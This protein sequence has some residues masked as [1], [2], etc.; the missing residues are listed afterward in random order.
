MSTERVKCLI[1]G[2]GPAGYTAAIYTGRANINP[3]LYEG[4]QPGGQ[5]TITTEV[6]KMID[7]KNLK[8][9]YLFFEC[10]NC[11]NF[12]IQGLSCHSRFCP[13]CGK[14]Y[15]DARAI[16]VS[17]KCLKVPHRHITWTISDK[18]RPYFRKYHELYD[19]L[20]GAVNDALTY[21]IQGKSKAAKERG[22]C[23]GFIS[24]IHTFG[25][26]M[27]FNPHIHTLVAECT[28]DKNGNQKPYS[29]FNYESLRKSFMK[30]LI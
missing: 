13:S 19:E 4:I 5:L 21:L 18:L 20:F 8:K 24:T 22:E 27:G 6:E 11:D 10:P 29:Y 16:E 26:D 9:G 25:R 7:C 3:V 2:S 17:R 12:H 28:I 1:I 15:R 30:Q 23:L 14:K